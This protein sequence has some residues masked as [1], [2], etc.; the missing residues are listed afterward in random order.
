[1]LEMGGSQG[2][3]WCDVSEQCTES[4]STTEEVII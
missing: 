3:G 2:I 1:M 4:T